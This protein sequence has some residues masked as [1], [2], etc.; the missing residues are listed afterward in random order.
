M[1]AQMTASGKKNPLPLPALMPAIFTFG[2]TPTIP[3][4]FLAAAIVPAVCVP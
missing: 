3:M 1:N 4:P 2:A